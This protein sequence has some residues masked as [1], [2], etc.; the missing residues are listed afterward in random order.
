[1][2]RLPGSTRFDQCRTRSYGVR[3]DP[4]QRGCALSLHL[5]DIL[6]A[7]I[8]D[9]LNQFVVVVRHHEELIART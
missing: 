4:A 1:M 5:D 3:L 9:L 6:N 7:H 2:L 8:L